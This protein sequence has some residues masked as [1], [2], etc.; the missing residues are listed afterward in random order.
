MD[1]HS[2]KK[3]AHRSFWLVTP[4]VKGEC[5]GLVPGCQRF[6]CYRRKPRNIN[7]S[8]LVPTGKTGERGDRTEF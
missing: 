7:L 5:P 2:E 4:P 1:I 8:A 6:M 3:K